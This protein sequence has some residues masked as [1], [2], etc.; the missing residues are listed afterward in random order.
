MCS[1]RLPGRATIIPTAAGRQRLNTAL[2]LG[3][4]TLLIAMVLMLTGCATNRYAQFCSA[5]VADGEAME[6]ELSLLSLD[7]VLD[8]EL[9]RQLP[10][11]LQS[12]FLCWYKSEEVMVVT[13]RR[14]KNSANYGYTFV[15]DGEGWVLTEGPPIILALP[16]SL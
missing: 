6:G 3:M 11:Q 1:S 12:E 7:P 16:H 5:L 15:R 9:R 14:F 4:R 8:T 13:T 10:G 2:D